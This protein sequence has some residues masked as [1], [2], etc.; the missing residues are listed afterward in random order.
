MRK[1]QF[2]ISIL[3]LIILKSVALNPLLPPGSNFDLSA[4]KLQTLDANALFAEITS[5]QLVANYN[6]NLFFTDTADGAMV[7]KV[8]SNGEPSSGN[9]GYPRVELRQIASGANWSISDPK[10]HYLNA[11]CKV[12][13]VAQAK[14]QT[15]IGQIHGSETNSE[16]LKIRWTGYLPEQCRI[17]A[18]YELNDATQAE[19][20]VTLATG[21]SL[22]DLIDYTITMKNGTITCTVNDVSAAQTYTSAFFGTTDQYY[23][24]AGN[25]LQYNNLTVPDPTI[26]YGQNQFYKLSLVKGI[27]SELTQPINTN[28]EVFQLVASKRIQVHYELTATNNVN[29]TMY[30]LC[31]KVVKY[32]ICNTKQ[33]AG[34][35][36]QSF[37]ISD[38]EGGIYL[39]KLSTE[40]F[41]KTTKI[42]NEK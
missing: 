21:L 37:D 33:T 22:G 20:G 2:V 11:Q 31:G 41:S 5:N 42:L 10:E 14:P 24:K 1:R 26:I 34:N 16:L 4:W 23:F 28:F 15:I 7:F 6:S 30:N 29:V 35:Y 13:S 27:T 12:I 38:L 39:L 36:N 17:E 8:P 3:L 18:R 32:L 19:Y 9:T 40:S 25:Y